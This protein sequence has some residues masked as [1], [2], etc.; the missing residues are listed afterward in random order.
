MEILSQVS[1]FL[2]FQLGSIAH[3][4]LI[5]NHGWLRCGPPIDGIRNACQITRAVWTVLVVHGRVDLLVLRNLQGYHH[6]GPWSDY[7]SVSTS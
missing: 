3:P 5:R 4:V 7:A 1:R 2:S 6:W